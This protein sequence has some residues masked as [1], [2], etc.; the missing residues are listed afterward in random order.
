MLDTQRKLAAAV[1]EF[2]PYADMTQDDVD[3]CARDI[4]RDGAWSK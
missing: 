2:K 1:P 4:D 3:D